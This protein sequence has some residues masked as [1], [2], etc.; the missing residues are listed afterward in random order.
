VLTGRGWRMLA[1][2]ASAAPEVKSAS[3]DAQPRVLH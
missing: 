1:H 2:H 3:R